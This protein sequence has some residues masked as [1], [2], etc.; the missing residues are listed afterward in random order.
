MKSYS[1]EES[2]LN[3]WNFYDMR[4]TQLPSFYWALAPATKAASGEAR[5]KESEIRPVVFQP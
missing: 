2:R 4:I 5:K 3:G 1:F